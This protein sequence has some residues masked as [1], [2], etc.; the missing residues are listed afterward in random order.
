M[1]TQLRIGHFSPDAPAVNVH[2]DGE[3]LL[4]DVSFG[5]LT[6]HIDVDAG[7]YDVEIVPAAGGDAVIDTTVEIE[8]DTSHT[9]LAI[10]AV[11]DIEALV[12]TD[13]QPSVDT[14]AARIRFVHLA[15]DAP[16]VDV[17]AGGTPLIEHVAF[18]DG[19]MP[20]T[21]DATTYDI[22]VQA[23]SSGDAVLRLTDVNFDGAT[24]YTVFV[25]GTLEDDSL[26][27]VLVPDYVTTDAD[28]RTAAAQ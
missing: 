21:I 5:M 24:S 20:A 11:A 17:L 22:D 13:E 2:I 10:G 1:N 18:G 23:S 15:P 9:V 19:S 16:A 7:S 3:L 6:E 25:T 12:L 8:S 28:E 26:D 4:E 27:A 14:D